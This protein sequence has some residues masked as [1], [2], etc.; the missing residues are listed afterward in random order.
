MLNEYEEK[1]QNRRVQ[2]QYYKGWA[3]TRYLS[4]PKGELATHFDESLDT[5][6][7][8][9]SSWGGPDWSPAT[10]S[11]STDAPRLQAVQWGQY[12]Q[13]TGIQEL[14]ATWV[15]IDRRA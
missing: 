13:G 4:C 10:S 2:T 15:Q 1:R 9:P 12:K 3:Y 5:G 11:D 7:V 14:V 8:L 6:S